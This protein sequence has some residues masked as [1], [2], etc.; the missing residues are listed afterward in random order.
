MIL[1]FRG[2]VLM[3]PM[4]QPSKY[5]Y[6]WS[7]SCRW[8]TMSLPTFSTVQWHSYLCT[9]FTFLLF[10]IPLVPF[11]IHRNSISTTHF[12]SSHLSLFTWDWGE[13]TLTLLSFPVLTLYIVALSH[14]SQVSFQCYSLFTWD[15]VALS[16]WSQHITEASWLLIPTCTPHPGYRYLEGEVGVALKYPG[17]PLT[18]PSFAPKKKVGS[19]PLA[20]TFTTNT[21]LFSC[22]LISWQTT[23][24]QMLLW[25]VTSTECQ[26]HCIYAHTPMFAYAC[27]CL[28]CSFQI[29]LL[30]T[31]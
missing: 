24:A 16:H 4:T 3:L 1:S 11:G 18:I 21:L 23:V 22:L 19:H 28:F 7:Y 15:W 25:T 12:S 8:C 14:P 30:I 5:L 31:V 10:T 13:Y 6:C 27:S 29:T 20:R 2:W 17:L 26:M 9:Y